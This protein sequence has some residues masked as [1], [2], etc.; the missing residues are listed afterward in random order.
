[1][2]ALNCQVLEQL[3]VNGNNDSHH[4]SLGTLSLFTGEETG[5][6]RLNNLPKFTQLV[7][8]RDGANIQLSLLISKAVLHVGL[9]SFIF[10]NSTITITGFD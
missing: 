10:N 6:H 5:L 4:L 8:V 9:Y 3:K 1:M 7:N 2:R